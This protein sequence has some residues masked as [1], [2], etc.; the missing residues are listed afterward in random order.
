MIEIEKTE[1][2]VNDEFYCV[3]IAVLTPS[4]ELY[5][6]EKNII[7]KYKPIDLEYYSE[8]DETRDCIVTLYKINLYNLE[9]TKIKEERFTIE[10]Q[11]PPNLKVHELNIEKIQGYDKYR[12]TFKINGKMYAKFVSGDVYTKYK[13]CKYSDEQFVSLFAQ[14]FLHNE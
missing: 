2:E 4:D 7:L 5:A 11:T 6:Y 14:E 3:N 10:I 1:L 9:I 8:H 13:L 12:M